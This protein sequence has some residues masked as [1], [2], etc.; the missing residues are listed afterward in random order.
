[1]V[2]PILAALG[3]AWPAVA[4]IAGSLLNRD[5]ARSAEN[6]NIDFQREMAQMGVRWRVADAKAAG[7]HPLAALGAAPV[8]A[9]PV[10]VG[11]TSMGSA[12]AALGQNISRAVSAGRT[13]QENAAELAR[14]MAEAQIAKTEAETALMYSQINGMRQAGVSP[15]WE[16]VPSQVT[17]ADSRLPSVEAGP[18]GPGFKATRI[19]NE[20]W[21]IPSSQLTEFAEGAGPVLST[22][23]VPWWM[24]QQAQARAMEE[25]AYDQ[26]L[27]EKTGDRAYQAAVRELDRL[28]PGYWLQRVRGG[29][30]IRKRGN[31]TFGL[32]FDDRT[33]ISPGIGSDEWKPRGGRFHRGLVTQE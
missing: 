4:G 33:R 18:A 16:R 17:A 15:D 19:G 5:S 22:F 9:S 13:E 30:E 26:A 7:L 10:A 24:R 27:A 21:D 29:W 32:T 23:M 28:G 31:G 2:M 3:S 1:M 6:R 11:D 20:V 25:R 14:K 8:S 12:L